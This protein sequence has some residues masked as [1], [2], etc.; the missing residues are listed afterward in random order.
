MKIPGLIASAKE[1]AKLT[2]E[3]LQN[4][5]DSLDAY[6]KS[7]IPDH[8]STLAFDQQYK[9]TVDKLQAQT[10]ANVQTNMNN[11]NET[12]PTNDMNTNT[13]TYYDAW[14]KPTLRFYSF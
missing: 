4:K 8:Q 11:I 1:D 10:I 5:K 3:Q 12:Y 2:N 13:N 6:L 14:M 7:W 9:G